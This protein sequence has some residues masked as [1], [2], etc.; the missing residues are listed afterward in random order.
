[1]PAPRADWVGWTE[2]AV[3]TLQ[4]EFLKGKSAAQ[5]AGAIGC[6]SRNAVIG[7]LSRLG[8][9][10]DAGPAFPRIVAA[11]MPAPKPKRDP[12]PAP[13]PRS[14]PSPTARPG[15]PPVA[16]SPARPAP[17]LALVAPPPAAAAGPFAPER[18][19]P[20]LEL[21]AH[22]CKWPVADAPGEPGLYLFCNDA[23]A[24]DAAIY[25]AHHAGQA[26][27]R[28]PRMTIGPLLRLSRAGYSPA[29]GVPRDAA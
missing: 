29:Q 6:P 22:R 9:V 23:A 3:A 20:M 8:L 5:I 26:F 1:M 12:K 17:A 21:L 10:R 27:S 13:V 16:A 14:P 4:S 11:A 15:P 28:S 18:P 19:V 2:T 25:C 7:K 24:D